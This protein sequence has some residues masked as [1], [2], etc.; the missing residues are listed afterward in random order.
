M[1]SWMW[2]E[3]DEVVHYGIES[4]LRKPPRVV[5]VPGRANRFIAMLARKLPQRWAL[6]LTQRES[7]RWRKQD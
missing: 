2:M 1:P 7:R 6:A 4:V 3:A 5:A